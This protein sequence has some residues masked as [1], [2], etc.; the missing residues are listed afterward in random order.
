MF[1]LPTH[2]YKFTNIFIRLMET[3]TH[4]TSLKIGTHD[5][6][7]H[8]DEVTACALL[9]K[10]SNKFRGAEIVRTRNPNVLDECDIIVDVGGKH[11]PPKYLDHHQR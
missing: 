3:E 11:V 10:Y 7:F 6:A 1:R 9:T 2:I 4:P 8:C 5:G